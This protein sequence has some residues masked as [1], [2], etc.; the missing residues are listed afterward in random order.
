M[1]EEV[2]RTTVTTVEGPG[3]SSGGYLIVGIL[4]GVLLIAGVAAAIIGLPQIEAWWA[5]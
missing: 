1:V 2:K 3:D 5:H 4:V